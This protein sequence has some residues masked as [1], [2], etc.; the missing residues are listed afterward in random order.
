MPIIYCICGFPAKTPGYLRRHLRAKTHAKWL[1]SGGWPGT[2]DW[3]GCNEPA[4]LGRGN[5]CPEHAKRQNALCLEEAAAKRA[6]G[7]C[8]CCKSQARPG[9]R[10]CGPC[11]ETTR[12]AVKLW[13]KEH[14][15]KYREIQYRHTR[16][17]Q[18]AIKGRVCCWCG[19]ADSETCWSKHVSRCSAC[20]RRFWRNG[21]CP[22]CG[23]PLY[24]GGRECDACEWRSP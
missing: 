3:Y 17:R 10:R 13:R 15:E 19:R 14:P 20:A 21:P 18:R 23:A 22:D 9:Q 1:S 16:R 8:A 4:T 24:G 2:C 5:K 6:K 11:A 12:E 7:Q